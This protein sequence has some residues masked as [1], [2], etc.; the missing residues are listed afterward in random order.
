LKP[1][2]PLIVIAAMLVLSYQ[3]ALAQSGTYVD[4]HDFGGTRANTDGLLSSS[5]VRFDKNGNMVGTSAEGGQNNRGM[6]WEITAAGV[7]KDLHDFGGM[8][9]NAS[10]GYGTDGTDPVAGVTVDKN[11]NIY[12]TTSTGGP[13]GAYP[14]DGMVWEITAAGEYKDLHDFGGTVTNAN[15]TSGP[16]GTL[17]S[18]GV[19]FDAAGNMFGTAQGGGPNG[20]SNGGDGMVWEITAA[21]VYKDLHDFGGSVINANG[22]SGPDGRGPTAAVTFD[23]SGNMIGTTCTGGPNGGSLGN[24]IVW[25]I[26]VAGDYKDLH[27]F[28]GTVTLSDGTTGHDGCI[29]FAGVTLDAA[30]NMVGTGDFGGANGAGI[31][32]EITAAGVYK[33]LHDFGGTV[34]NADGKSGP[35]G[36]QP[37]AGV[38]F[39]ASGNMFGTTTSGGPNAVL[40][41]PSG[42][43]WEITAAGV[44]KDVHDFG[45]TVANADG[46]IGPDGNQP[47]Y[48][49][50]TF[51]GSGN[52][53][54]TTQYGGAY[55]TGLVWE[56]PAGS[57]RTVA[58]V[59]LSPTAVTGGISSA[60]TV[61]LTQA[62]GTGGAVVSLSSSSG[63]ASVPST[64]TVAAGASSATFSIKTIGVN[65]QS[66][67]TI[68][69][70][71]AT[72][73]KAVTLTINPAALATLTIN[74]T[75]IGGGGTATG[76]VTLSGPAGSVATT[77]TLTSSDTAAATAPSSVYVPAGKTSGTFT[78]TTSAVTS[79][80]VVTITG[81]LSGQS[82]SATLTVAPAALALVSLS[83]ATLAGGNSSTGVVSLSG[84]AASG[85][86]IVFLG[87]SSSTVSV[88]GSVA[89]LA[90]Q[91]EA[92]FKVTTKPVTSQKFATITAT[93]GNVMKTASL[94]VTPPGVGSVNLSPNPVAGGTPSMGSV[95]LTG[96]APSGGMLVKLSSSSRS[97]VVPATVRVASGK[98]TATF[99]VRTV[100]VATNLTATITSV[101]ASTT[102]TV[103]LTVEPPTLKSLTLTPTSVKGGDWSLAKVTLTSAAPVGGLTIA[104]SS[105]VSGATVP[106]SVKIAPGATSAS[107]AVKTTAVTATTT[108]TISATLQAASA[109][110]NLTIKP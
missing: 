27:D 4:R 87:S 21:G 80:T 97:A 84:N 53:V 18:A 67:A 39:D 75:S 59:T 108:A 55:G 43:I 14:G 66:T 65:S 69:A 42:M 9:V 32:W 5:G 86:L 19:T 35:D 102:Q 12:G 68:N 50:V 20:D 6:V 98:T 96:P 11:G 45:G 107:C 101:V 74:P 91:S 103:S 92:T 93:A 109:T 49:G 24:G 62:A 8:V 23:K 79:S 36:Y 41:E 104:L 110:A 29:P 64:V 1:F 44:Y 33:D 34:T 72:G 22:S 94:T 10:G 48:S 63:D 73:S 3:S 52:I 25:Q 77:V 70:G 46:T 40:D 105:N 61:T 54:G 37:W 99:T 81:T 57:A 83:P 58:G 16:D 106:G 15:G 56:I 78:I 71:T 13:N 85:G 30:G 60:G 7:Y 88:P 28:G 47:Y 76:T 90:G 31:V 82:Q 51:D 100:A 38:T 17:P 89:V 95:T 2:S 26:T